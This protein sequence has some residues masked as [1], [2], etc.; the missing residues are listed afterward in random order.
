MGQTKVLYSYVNGGTV[1]YPPPPHR[2][3]LG[4]IRLVHKPSRRQG[5]LRTAQLYQIPF[6]NN[7]R[8]MRNG[9]FLNW[10]EKEVTIS[11]IYGVAIYPSIKIPLVNKLIS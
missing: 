2:P 9:I 7:C 4:Y 6:F 3:L 5:S 1:M 8:Q 10:K 11:S